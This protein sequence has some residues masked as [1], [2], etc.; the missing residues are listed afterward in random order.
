MLKLFYLIK[1]FLRGG[2]EGHSGGAM[3]GQKGA[4]KWWSPP[5]K[6][7][8][9]APDWHVGKPI[10][11]YNCYSVK[12]SSLFWQPWFVSYSYG[13]LTLFILLLLEL[14][15]LLNCVKVLK[16]WRYKLQTLSF[17]PPLLKFSGKHVFFCFFQFPPLILLVSIYVILLYC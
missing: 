3:V 10:W 9:S 14:G 15:L 6:L 7:V 16:L 11:N 12:W 4:V 2:P 5:W 1:I 8:W 17:T 13:K